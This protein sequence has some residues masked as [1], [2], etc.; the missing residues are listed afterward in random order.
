MI[1]LAD[2][3]ARASLVVACALTAAIFLLVNVEVVSRY[4]FGT[5]TLIADEYAAYGFA[6]MVYLGMVYAV[7]HDMLIRIDVPGRWRRFVERPAL[8]LF[9]ALATLVLNVS[10][11]YALTVTFL[12]S[13]RFQS[14]SIQVS[15][16][17]IAWPQGLA[18]A[19]LALLVVISVVCIFRAVRRHGPR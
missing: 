15:K 19:A 10:L 9:G 13:V 3:I 14:R 4:V 8:K 11:L 2:G 5:S 7:Q 18:L 17:L 16:T 6:V 1:R 12:A